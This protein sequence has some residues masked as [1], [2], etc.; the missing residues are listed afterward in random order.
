MSW[1]TVAAIGTNLLGSY[2]SGSAASSAANTAAAAQEAA[3]RRAAQAAMFKPVGITT[4]FGSSGFQYDRKG[5]L[6]GAGYT[7]SPEITA[8]QDRLSA[9]YGDSLGQAEQARALGIPLGMAGQ[10]LF[11]LGAQ[12]LATSPEEARQQYMNEQMAILDPVRAREEA[13]LGSSVFGRGRAGLNVGSAGQPELFALAQAR[14]EQEL[15]LAA[16]A[17]QAAQRRIGFGSS[18]FGEGAQ[19]FGTQ[20]DLQTKA[21]APFQTQFG[22]SQLLEQAAQQPLDISAQLGGRSATAG[23][24]VGKYLLEGGL[25]SAKTQLGGNLIGPSAMANAF[26]KI[27]YSNLFNKLMGPGA[28]TQQY[29]YGSDFIPYGTSY[30]E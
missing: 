15:K 17:E 6:I 19:K 16:E 1:G 5:N 27:D 29:T 20:Y 18:L 7:A 22:L 2:L 10:R 13:R 3:A 24:N 30:G 28:G 26:S 21:L 23:A 25:A 11:G 4:R 14:R 9:L 12:Y 8:L